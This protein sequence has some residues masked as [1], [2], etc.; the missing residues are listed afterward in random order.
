MSLDKT[1]ATPVDTHVWQVAQR[2]YLPHL[3]KY[4]TLTDKI[5]KEIGMYILK[6]IIKIHFK[7]SVTEVYLIHTGKLNQLI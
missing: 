6:I 7:Q 3:K 4:K 1:E 2:D 5:Y